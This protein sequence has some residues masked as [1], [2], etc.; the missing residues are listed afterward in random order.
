MNHEKAIQIA[1]K[2]LNEANKE[3]P[4]IDEETEEN[5]DTV[6]IA[7]NLKK[8]LIR[9]NLKKKIIKKINN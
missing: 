8:I 6:Y 3:L 7:K 9:G 1:S 4:N 2:A 5:R